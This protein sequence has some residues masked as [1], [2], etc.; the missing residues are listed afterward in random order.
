MDQTLSIFC[1]VLMLLT[2]EIISSPYSTAK[3]QDCRD[4]AARA[5]YG[6]LFDYVMS[7]V[8]SDLATLFHA[9]NRD[10]GTIG[11]ARDDHPLPPPERR[12]IYH[13]QI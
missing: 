13:V 12:V 7:L 3:A 2:G 10:V 11:K 9:D 5:I 8:N 4:A 6:R 1:Y